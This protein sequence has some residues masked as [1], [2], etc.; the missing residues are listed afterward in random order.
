MGV[1]Y[2]TNQPTRYQDTADRP[3]LPE[4]EIT[5]AMIEAGV[6]AL[7]HSMGYQLLGSPEAGVEAV[8]LAMFRRRAMG[9]KHP[10]AK[11][12]AAR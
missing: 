2:L 10:S 8:F 4:I 5:P 11:T 7:Y 1:I 6:K 9:D 3:V 12:P